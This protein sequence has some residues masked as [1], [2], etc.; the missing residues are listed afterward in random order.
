MRSSFLPFWNKKTDKWLIVGLGNPG[1]KYARNRHNIGFMCLDEFARIHKISLARSR[2][3]AKTGEGKIDS[4]EVVLAKPLTFVNLSGEAVGKLVRKYGVK[5]ERLIVVCDDLDL[6]L[7][8]TRLRLGGSSGH[9]GIKSIVEHIG[10]EDFIRVR[11]GIGRPGE[12]QSVATVRG[13]VINHV[14]GDFSEEEQKM[15]G[16][17]VPRVGEIL[18]CLLSEGLT[19]AMNKFNSTDFRKAQT[20]K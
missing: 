18:V 4:T 15:I 2:Y 16:K 13:D 20:D 17:I 7:G 10:S 3:R 1:E 6:P 19:A 9:N 5:P 8:R 14:L 11:V 12:E